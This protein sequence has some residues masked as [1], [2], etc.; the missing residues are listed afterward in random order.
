VRAI[1]GRGPKPGS[2]FEY[3]GPF[4]EAV[5]LGNVALRAKR[6][7]NWDPIAM[8]VTNIPEANQFITR[9]YRSGW[10]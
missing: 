5:L 4:T 7:I 1:K 8:K 3:S 6:R 10:M 2:N 9:E